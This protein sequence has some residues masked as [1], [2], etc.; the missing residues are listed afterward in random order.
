M[1][2]RKKALKTS[3]T[4]FIE[5]AHLAFTRMTRK[6]QQGLKDKFKTDTGYDRYASLSSI[7]P[8]RRNYTMFFEAFNV[9]D[10]DKLLTK[11]ILRPPL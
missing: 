2:C 7:P 4:G 3:L 5:L 1:I 9:I 6:I 11:I 8:E 10:D